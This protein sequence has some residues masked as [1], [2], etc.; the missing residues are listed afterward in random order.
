[1]E[2]DVGDVRP[3]VRTCFE[4]ACDKV[5]GS[6]RDWLGEGVDHPNGGSVKHFLEILRLEG[7]G[8]AEEG[9]EDATQGPNVG[10]DWVVGTTEDNFGGY[11]MRRAAPLR[12]RLV[13]LEEGGK[14]KVA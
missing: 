12:E 1:M 4:N 9:V 5:A 3:L 7:E 14:S 10:G 6:L 11:G 13:K 2:L 8:T